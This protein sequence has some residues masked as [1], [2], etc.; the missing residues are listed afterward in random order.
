MPRRLRRRRVA[1]S[2][3]VGVVEIRYMELGTAWERDRGTGRFGPFPDRTSYAR[4]WARTKASIL[5]RWIAAHPGTRPAAWWEFEAPKAKRQRLGGTGSPAIPGDTSL[6]GQPR[7]FRED[8]SRTD[9]PRYETDAAYLERLGL[10]TP[11]ERTA[12]GLEP[13]AAGRA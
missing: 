11:G 10:L 5:R 6:R 8:Y 12:L 7:W 13:R 3:F 9:P 2:G 4:A 1:R